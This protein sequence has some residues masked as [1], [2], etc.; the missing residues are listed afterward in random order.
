MASTSARRGSRPSARA[1]PKPS[2]RARRSSAPT[3][4]RDFRIKRVYAPAAADDG[5]RVLVDRLWPRGISKDK[6]GIDFWLKDISPS[7]ALRRRV[8]ADPSKWSEFVAAYGREL[9]QEPARSAVATLRAHLRDGPVTLLFAA[10]DEER[11]N[12]VALK[13]WLARKS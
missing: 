5:L 13:H 8:H 2:V 1:K 11:N 12:A 9:A 10:R 6:A 7:D 3:G 4:G